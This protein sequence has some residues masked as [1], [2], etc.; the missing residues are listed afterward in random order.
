MFRRIREEDLA[1]RAW[2]SR[3]LCTV[4]DQERVITVALQVCMVGGVY[5]AVSLACFRCADGLAKRGIAMT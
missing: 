2:G 1:G 5:M 3:F 4:D